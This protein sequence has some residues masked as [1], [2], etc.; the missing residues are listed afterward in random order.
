MVRSDHAPRARLAEAIVAGDGGG[1]GVCVLNLCMAR[2]R[3]TIDPR[4]PTMPGRSTSG[5][6]QL[7][8]H[9]LHQARSAVRCSASRMEGELHP[10]KNRSQDGLRHVVPTFLLMDDNANELLC[11]LVWPLQR[12]QWVLLC[13]FLVGALPYSHYVIRPF[14]SCGVRV[15]HP[16][17]YDLTR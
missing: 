1:M 5:C 14:P 10:S 11:F 2:S 16:A 17:Q 15:L 8:R 7:G 3:M 6:H 12:Q 4:I 13:N 9:C